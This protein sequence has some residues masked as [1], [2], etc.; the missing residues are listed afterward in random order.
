MNILFWNIRGLESKGRKAQLKKILSEHRVNCVCISETIK[1]NF[2]N[3]EASA[4]GGENYFSWKWV[5]SQGHSG[6]LLIGIDEDMLEVSDYQENRHFQSM[7][8]E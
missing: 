8:L 4:L 6:G 7:T 1:Q 3:R 5:P 2:T